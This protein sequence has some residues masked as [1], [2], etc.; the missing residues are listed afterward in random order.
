MNKKQKKEQ[1]QKDWGLSVDGAIPLVLVDESVDRAIQKILQ[2][3]IDGIT[4]IG[5]QLVFVE[6]KDEES[7]HSLMQF[8]QKYPQSVK[9]LSRS[10]I[11]SDAFD[12]A[13]LDELNPSRLAELREHKLVPL[14]GKGVVPFDPIQEKGNGFVF[15]PKN[16]WS[17][18]AAFVR[19]AE[20]YRFPYDWQNIVKAVAKSA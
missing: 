16:S 2:E 5:I 9:V 20:T 17:L 18:F 11:D 13:L 19:A 4:S 8:Q 7:R 12:I 10:Q 14:A 6:P 1:K 15:E 3:I